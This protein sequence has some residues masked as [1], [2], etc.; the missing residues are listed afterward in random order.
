MFVG[1]NAAIL[2]DSD[3]PTAFCHKPALLL[4][5]SGFP[6]MANMEICEGYVDK[7]LMECLGIT[8]SMRGH[9][10]LR[11]RPKAT[12]GEILAASKK[13]NLYLHEDRMSFE[14]WL[15]NQDP[16]MSEAVIR[17]CKDILKSFYTFWMQVKNDLA[18]QDAAFFQQDR[19]NCLMPEKI[20]S[21]VPCCRFVYSSVLWNV[22][23]PW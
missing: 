8:R 23:K 13:M 22:C 16:M 9:Q 18:E 14:E 6:A 20:Q 4:Q 10:L 21:C 2:Q 15:L 19:E 12:K 5:A 7:Y 1:S 3:Q 11:V 17:Q